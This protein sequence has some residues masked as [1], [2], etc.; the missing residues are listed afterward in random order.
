MRIMFLIAAINCLVILGADVQNSYINARTRE[1]VYMITGPELGSNAGRPATIVRAL[2]GLKSSGARWRDHLAAIFREA[3]FTNSKADP[4]VWMRKAQ[5]P[6]KFLYWEYVL[7]YVDDILAVSHDPRAILDTILQQVT[8][9]PGSI[10]EPKNYLGANISKCT[11]F[12][13]NNQIPQ[14]Q[15]WTMSAQEYIR[16]AVE[17]VKRELKV[18]NQYLPKK[19]ETPLSSGYRP[20]LDFSLELCPQMTNYY[21]GLIGILR[22]IVEL[23]R[24]NIMVPVSMLSRYLISPREGHLQQ[25]YQIFAYLKQFNHPALVFDESEPVLSTDHFNVCD[26]SSHYPDAEKKVPQDAPEALGHSVVTTCYVDADHAG[27][28]VTRRPHTGILIYVNC[29]PI[30]WFSKRQNTVESSTFSS[31]YIALKVAIELIESLRYKLRMFGI[32]IDGS[33][34]VFCDNEAVVQ[35]STRP[36]STLKKKHVSIAYHRCR[37]AQVAGYVRIGF[38]KGMENLADLL[39]KTLPGPR[40][41]KLMEYVFHWKRAH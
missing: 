37:E 36:E 34:I 19:I 7:C 11:V 12:D 31:E 32:P 6:N 28:H 24:I 23:G 29:A 8:L 41:R 30:I 18:N 39:T 21:Q 10:E 16:R 1:K 40:L 9:K 26:W 25:A 4:D 14:K 17:E 13:G 22:W 33:T 3:G 20:E 38:I 27:C 5:K 2:Y 35:N 15:V